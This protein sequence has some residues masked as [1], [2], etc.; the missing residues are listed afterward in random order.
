MTPAGREVRPAR[1]QREGRLL[2]A[3]YIIFL[4]AIDVQRR[5]RKEMEAATRDQM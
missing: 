5:W 4:E 3:K 1:S 2:D